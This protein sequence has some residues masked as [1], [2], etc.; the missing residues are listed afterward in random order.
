M[1]YYSVT[2]K[3]GLTDYGLIFVEEDGI[4]KYLLLLPKLGTTGYVNTVRILHI[5]LLIMIGWRYIKIW[6]RTCQDH[7][8]VLIINNILVTVT[9]IYAK[10]IRY[11]NFIRLCY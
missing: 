9:N 8:V 3:L 1:A 2:I 7:L 10:I 4:S 5:V 6:T 11:G